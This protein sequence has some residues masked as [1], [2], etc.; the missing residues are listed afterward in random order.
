MKY[1]RMLHKEVGKI[2]IKDMIKGVNGNILGLDS[3]SD[4]HDE[5][6]IP[7]EP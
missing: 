1:L 6:T 3:T 5:S 7:T 2:M 4:N